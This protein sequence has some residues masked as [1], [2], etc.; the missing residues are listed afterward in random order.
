MRS[1]LSVNWTAKAKADLKSIYYHLLENNSKEIS[2]KIRDEIFSAP[3]TIIF[4]EQYQFDD[5]MFECRRMVIRNYKILYSAE[6]NAITVI[7][8]FNSH[9][10]PSKMR[11]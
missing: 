11:G 3:K 1:T 8:V 6:E 10:H 4:P 9:R 5:F 2:L 7:G